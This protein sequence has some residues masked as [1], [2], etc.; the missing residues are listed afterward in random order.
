M[1]CG[2]EDCIKE[3]NV[4]SF[5]LN[6]QWRQGATKMAASASPQPCISISPSDTRACHHAVLGWME[7]VHPFKDGKQKEIRLSDQHADS[8]PCS[9]IITRA[10]RRAGVRMRSWER[11][12]SGISP[13]S[14]GSDQIKQNIK[15]HTE[16]VVNVHLKPTQASTGAKSSPGLACLPCI[17]PLLL[18]LSPLPLSGSAAVH[19]D[20]YWGELTKNQNYYIK[21]VFFPSTQISPHT[22][23]ITSHRDACTSK[24]EDRK[25]GQGG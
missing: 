8:S 21:G 15:L 9:H 20:S 4:V 25:A 3:L 16:A 12:W 6:Q 5:M 24:T 17:N 14:D 11:Q 19:V 1:A 7:S 13:F 2:S 10:D 18:V 22:W 23:F